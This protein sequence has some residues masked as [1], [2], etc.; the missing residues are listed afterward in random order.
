MKP[1][2]SSS[3]KV[4]FGLFVIWS[5]LVQVC[6]AFYYYYDWDI[7]NSQH[8][9][10]N[11]DPTRVWNISDL[12]IFYGVSLDPNP[13]SLLLHKLKENRSSSFNLTQSQ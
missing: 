3:V 10:V 6:G 2:L 9:S 7:K 1:S 11:S 8:E 4:I 12:Q 5:V 13:Y